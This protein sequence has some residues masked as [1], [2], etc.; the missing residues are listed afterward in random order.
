MKLIQR[1]RG[2]ID[3]VRQ[4]PGERSTPAASAREQNSAIHQDLAA[5]HVR[6]QVR[7]QEKGNLANIVGLTHP[8]HWIPA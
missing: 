1:K 3:T 7:G 4:G 2:D 8:S 5:R 6:G